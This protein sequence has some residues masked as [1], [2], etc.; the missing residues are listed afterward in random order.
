MKR[1]VPILLFFI[2][3]FSTHAQTLQPVSPGKV[4]VKL[5]SVDEAIVKAQVVRS[6]ATGTV[7]VGIRKFDALLQQYGATQMRRIFPDAGK[8]EEKHRKYGL[9]LWYEITVSDSANQDKASK[10]FV[11]QGL[12]EVA[13]P[14]YKIVRIDG[15]KSDNA[16][17]SVKA[18]SSIVPFASS[19]DPYLPGQWH[20]NNDGSFSG[21]VA[22]VDISLFN[23][24]DITMGDPRVVVCV[25]DGGVDYRHED[26]AT[27]MWVNEAELNGLPNIDDDRN[28][29]VDDIYGY[30][31]VDKRGN[32]T[33]D[34]H[35]THVA[36]TVSAVTNNTKGVA[37]VAGGSGTTSGVR[38]MTSQIFYGDDVGDV[39]QALV[40]GADNGAVIS[41]NSWGYNEPDT[42]SQ[43]EQTAIRYFIAE[44]GTDSEGKPR[45]NTPMVGGIV[46]FA[47]G[48][49]IPTGREGRF[50]P[51]AFPAVVSVAA[52]T[53]AGKKADYSNYGSWVSISAPG[54][55]DALGVY[56]T[57]PSIL[58]V[59][60]YGYM[61]GTSMA[62]PH[63]SGVAALILSK[64]GSESYTPEM[65]K[66]R[67]LV[68]T[69]PINDLRYVGK[70]GTGLLDAAAA[71]TM[72][73]VESFSIAPTNLRM[74]V[75]ESV[76]LTSTVIPADAT[77]S[78]ITWSSS[79]SNVLT[80]S[81]AGLMRVVSYD[82][83]NPF[84][85]IVVTATTADGRFEATCTVEVF[86][87]VEVPE[88]FSPNGDG[89]NDKL[90]M[91]LAENETYGFRVF[92]R[93]G[94]LCYEAQNYTND[95]DAVAN[96]GAN[97]GALVRAGTY[98]YVLTA[99]KGGLVKKGFFIVRY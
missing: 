11:D 43:V 90:V 96:R 8:Y 68:S 33:F 14:A 44:A 46:I 45:P 92:D 77:Y 52:L 30:N 38:I 58:G 51:A 74:Y 6:A 83:S 3:F 71:L 93:S 31:F 17:E 69:K 88:G 64:F 41:Q 40:Y 75:G 63:V 98:Y 16:V 55:T 76:Q 32:I 81:Q 97:R 42:Y 66:S 60:R 7:S 22:G 61:S 59:S 94:Q 57:F 21:A 39:G 23:A 79:N 91:L 85:P 49:T 72:I 95:W 28:G 78:K 47:T 37:G 70:L 56:S 65:L 48:N 15:L 34:T 36:G 87:D 27:N 1:I 26:L 13:E 54:G 84:A 25:V 10:A 20:Y 67:L 2:S 73:P 18:K 12:A 53:A 29:Y 50:Y 89:I 82:A 99:L 35:G 86:K 24:W 19:N 9:H 4:R 62:C 80:V 5:K